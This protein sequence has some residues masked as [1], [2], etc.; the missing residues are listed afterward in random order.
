MNDFVKD[1]KL[2]HYFR[3]TLLQNL[4][5]VRQQIQLQIRGQKISGQLFHLPRFFVLVRA[6]SVQMTETLF[7]F[8]KNK[9]NNMAETEEIRKFLNMKPKALAGLTKQ[10]KNIF[11]LELKVPYRQCYPNATKQEYLMK[12]N[13]E[14][15]INVVTLTDPKMDVSQLWHEEDD[16]AQGEENGFLDISNQL[17][18]RPLLHQVYRKIE[19]TGTEGMSQLE[20]GAE[21]GLP[22][23]NAR[24]VL[25]KMQ[26]QRDL[27][28]YMK[29]EGRQ[30][31][32]K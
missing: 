6:T 4:L 24:S 29:D 28:F 10:R 3:T 19:E 26:R 20:I 27:K 25:R 18:N 9:P 12:T 14:K 23:L 32:S 1:S 30:R 11:K 17:L 7:N 16:A 22:K 21:F 5:V 13:N 15:K 2:L 31:V 8:L